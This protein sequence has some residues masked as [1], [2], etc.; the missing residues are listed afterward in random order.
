MA[1][2]VSR[3]PTP[4]A[5]LN[6]PGAPPSVQVHRGIWVKRVLLIGG[7][8]GIVAALGAVIPSVFSSPETG[9]Q[10]MYTVVP[11]DMTV[12]IT[13]QGTLESSDNIE[14]KNKVRGQNTVTWVI[15][16]GSVVKAGD[17]LVR[18][19]TKVI[20]ETVSDEIP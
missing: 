13:E 17:E 8:L 19:D 16:S 7:V 11:S 6:D 12:T 10:L 5:S 14:I 20:E 9:P 2:D 3:E 1:M 4:T 18:L 15:P